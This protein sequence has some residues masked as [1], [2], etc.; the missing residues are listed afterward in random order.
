MR[1]RVV[2]H[3]PAQG[4]REA[5]LLF[6]GLPLTTIVSTILAGLPPAA[7]LDDN[8][9]RS[10]SSRL[11]PRKGHSSWPTAACLSGRGWSA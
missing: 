10:T 7:V 5:G 6:I 11:G 2:L 3:H 8:H 9:A 4:D 1:T